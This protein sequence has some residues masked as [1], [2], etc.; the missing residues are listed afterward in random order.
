MPLS[1]PRL[2]GL[3]FE[4]ARPPAV[5]GLPR[6]DV[7]AFVGFASAGPVGVPVAVDDEVRFRE[8]FGPDLPLAWDPQR[9]ETVYAHL[10]PAVREFFRN[11]GRRCWIVRAGDESTLEAAAFRIPGMLHGRGRSLR[12]AFLLASSP[13]SW[14]DG[15][16]LNATLQ[17][18]VIPPVTR[19]TGGIELPLQSPE[20]LKLEWP[21]SGTVAFFLPVPG[22]PER[23][24]NERDRKPEKVRP[25]SHAY[26]F[27]AVPWPELQPVAQH[28]VFLAGPRH[29]PLQPIGWQ[30]TDFGPDPHLKIH[31]AEEAAPGLQPGCWI[32]ITFATGEDLEGG[33]VAFMASDPDGSADGGAEIPSLWAS[34][35]SAGSEPLAVSADS[36][37]AAGEKKG[38]DGNQGGGNQGGG[39][40]GGGNQ[41]GGEDP[42]GGQ[43][44][45]HNPGGGNQGGGE[46]PG[47]GGNQ[48]G[49]RQGDGGQGGGQNPGGGNQGG[50]GQGD[51][52]Q[53]GGQNPG[54]GNQGGDQNPGGGNQGGGFPG[55]DGHDEPPGDSHQHEI[56][57]EPALQGTRA[58]LLVDEVRRE[59]GETVVIIRQAWRTLHHT[60]APDS[61]TFA[62]AQASL[63]SVELWTR[64]G[65][66]TV[67]RLPNVGL[68][69]GHPRFL[70]SL[71]P[72]QVQ[73]APTEQL[74]QSTTDPASAQLSVSRLRLAAPDDRA[75]T[76][77]DEGGLRLLTRD[78]APVDASAPAVGAALVPGTHP[79]GGL[80][81]DEGDGSGG[82]QAYLPLGVP[83][84][85][86]DDFFQAA[87]TSGR[88][89]LERDGVGA[90]STRLFL[91]GD[92]ADESAETLLDTAFH[93]AYVAEPPR[94]PIRM[95]ALLPVEE[96]SLLSVPDAVHTG[97]ELRTVDAPPPAPE[98]PY[99][100]PMRQPDAEG[101]ILVQW[102]I[103]GGA[104]EY[105]LQDS[106]DPRF[107][108]GVETTRVTVPEDAHPDHAWVIRPR[109]CPDR[110]YFRIRVRTHA[111]FSAWSYTLLLDLPGDA[112]QCCGR[113]PLQAPVVTS[114]IPFG[115]RLAVF[116]AAAAEDPA[117]R[118]ARAAY[119]R[120]YRVEMSPEPTF[121]LAEL[122]YEGTD[123]QAETWKPQSGALF[124]RAASWLQEKPGY[125][126]DGCPPCIVEESPW[127]TTLPFGT[128]STQRW[129]MLSGAESDGSVTRDLHVSML[130]FCA[131][132]SDCFAVLALP[133]HHRE[134][135]ALAHA[136]WLTTVLGGI[137]EPG[138]VGAR[139]LSF[140]ALYHPWTVVRTSSAAAP[141]RA[142]PPDG[143]TTGVMAARANELG[144]W[145][146]PANRPLAGVAILDPKLPESVRATF[147]GRRVN[148]VAPFPRGFMTW[149]EETLSPDPELRGVGVRR[150]LILLRRLALR[151][152]N[153]YVF[154]PNDNTFRR[155]VQRQ[156]DA[157]LA[158]LYV[159]GAFAGA[160]HAEGYRVVTDDTVNPR[161]S[162]DLGR[163]VVELR[164]APSRPM[165]FLTVRL[166]Q[167][168]A[169]ITVL[170]G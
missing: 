18:T 57:G 156:F 1:T 157:L 83:T 48:G 92:L 152:G 164:V 119:D 121:S 144:A 122:L 125:G 74:V 100:V 155:L 11:G 124:F 168:G 99:L 147:L 117:L 133:R 104:L 118:D 91:D 87:H 24:R 19:E 137:A 109:P 53:G 97:W 44:G 47:G 43:G 170:E 37:P 86:R 105:E 66:G 5:P 2:P 32:R 76:A 81:D 130:R 38:G 95:H 108:A 59:Q 55:G 62:D 64:R 56:P 33:V 17:A 85:L 49:G 114:F 131:A 84:V 29:V 142:I 111:G 39:N 90:F 80:D 68:V 42:G 98:A 143:A 41:G 52:G 128:G 167:A 54:G 61:V 4:T 112:F 150:L 136:A 94:P 45:G 14:A 149:S 120:V 22:A 70:G 51:G 161:Q 160:T 72:D 107:R 20:L 146:A 138:D 8:V 129:E 123:T 69:P 25:F 30:V 15:M 127:S 31:L 63:V 34:Q 158:D 169:G 27:R 113:T 162:V 126:D 163:L 73:F 101:R 106:P 139:T 96:V 79:A 115:E 135:E 153:T 50:G 40:Q 103:V 145:A 77:A 140:G 148:A 102:G 67:V 28:S 89:A 134:P 75:Y 36:Q 6:M 10:A 82:F 154:E 9:G 93:N 3:R 151:E 60:R 110:L 16:S 65:D 141:L 78:D 58:Y 7:A 35:P 116:W 166:V 165:A 88:S 46:S 71:P 132:R 21:A 23:D 13:G 12:A 26:W 159:R